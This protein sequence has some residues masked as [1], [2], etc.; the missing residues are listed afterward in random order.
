MSINKCMDKSWYILQRYIDSSVKRD[1]QHYSKITPQCNNMGDSQN[2]LY[3]VKEGRHEK[4]ILFDS[5][6]VVTLMLSLHSE[7]LTWLAQK[8]SLL[9][10]LLCRLPP[11]EKY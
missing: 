5:C 8:L 4:Y 6:G 11:E 3:W 9:L 2:K 1:Y 10:L 7:A